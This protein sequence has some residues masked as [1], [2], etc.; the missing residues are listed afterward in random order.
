MGAAGARR[1]AGGVDV[2]AELSRA[3]GAP[4]GEP[5]V[6][7]AWYQPAPHVAPHSD[8]WDVP[9]EACRFGQSQLTAGVVLDLASGRQAPPAGAPV[10]A[11]IGTT[12]ATPRASVF[13]SVHA[14]GRHRDAVTAAVLSLL[15]DTCRHTR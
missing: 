14:D 4:D 11:S 8:G 6:L 1:L 10:P 12:A 7:E 13:V 5:A 9:A 3:G 15:T 2:L